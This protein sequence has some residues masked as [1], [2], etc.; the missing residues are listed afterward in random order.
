MNIRIERFSCIKPPLLLREVFDFLMQCFLF[1][2][3]NSQHCE[4]PLE[5]CERQRQSFKDELKVCFTVVKSDDSGKNSV[6]IGESRE[7]NKIRNNKEYEMPKINLSQ[8]IK[9]I[10]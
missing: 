6:K 8:K 7:G 10:D 5:R 9:I 4:I 1:H 3:L 2:F